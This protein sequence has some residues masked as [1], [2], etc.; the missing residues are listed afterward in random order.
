ML[1]RGP[2]PRGLAHRLSRAPRETVRFL[3]PV[4]EVGPPI[5]RELNG[6]ERRK[7]QGNRGRGMQDPYLGSSRWARAVVR[8][9]F[10]RDA[11]SGKPSPRY[12]VRDPEFAMPGPRSR[13]RSRTAGRMMALQGPPRDTDLAC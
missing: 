3:L 8:R 7:S 4:S 2:L 13:S 12:R 1:A 11:G 10:R 9:D 6:L 5:L